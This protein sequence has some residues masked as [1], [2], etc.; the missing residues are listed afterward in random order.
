MEA[1]EAEELDPGFVAFSAASPKT[2]YWSSRRE[3]SVRIEMKTPMHGVTPVL[4]QS[5]Q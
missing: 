4:T 2:R 3:A 1:G 5:R